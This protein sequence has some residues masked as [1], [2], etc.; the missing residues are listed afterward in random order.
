MRKRRMVVGNVNST[1][2]EKRLKSAADT[3]ESEEDDSCY[4]ED[5]SFR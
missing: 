3:V 2:T 4:D 1:G 5:D